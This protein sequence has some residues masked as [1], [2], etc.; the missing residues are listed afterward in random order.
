MS[1]FQDLPKTCKQE[2]N[3]PKFWTIVAKSVAKPEKAK[4]LSSKLNLKV[5]KYQHQTTSKLI[6]HQQQTTFPPKLSGAL[7]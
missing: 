1:R 3:W 2:K 6:K 5:K 4:I 7:K